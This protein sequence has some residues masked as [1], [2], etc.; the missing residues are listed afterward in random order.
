MKLLATFVS[1]LVLSVPALADHAVENASATARS[2]YRA[3]DDAESLASAANRDAGGWDRWDSATKST[4]DVESDNVPND[5]RRDTLREL[6]RIAHS[7]HYSLS[8]L[9]R[10]ARN[11]TDGIQPE[12]H[13]GD[14]IRDA[15]RLSQSQFVQLSNSYRNLSRYQYSPYIDQLYRSVQASFSSLEWTV[16]GRQFQ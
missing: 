3:A 12:D 14:R 11:A 5:H 16:Y 4:S 1:I 10:T 7:L 8:D 9:Y 13:R 6:G 15:F 2:A